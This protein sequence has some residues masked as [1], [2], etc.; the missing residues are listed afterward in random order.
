MTLPLVAGTTQTAMAP[1]F[2]GM[3]GT[4]GEAFGVPF[5]VPISTP[6][7]ARRLSARTAMLPRPAGR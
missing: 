1:A 3:V 7:L 4:L 2:V 5:V 6:Y